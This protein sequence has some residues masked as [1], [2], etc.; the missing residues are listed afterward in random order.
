MASSPRA[1]RPRLL[2]EKYGGYLHNDVPREDVELTRDGRGQIGLLEGHCAHRGASLE[3]AR[4]EPQGIRCCYHGWHYEVDGTILEMPGEPPGSTF[5]DRF[6]HGAYPTL[7]FQGL[8]FTYMGPPE[9][10]PAFPIYDV[11][12]APG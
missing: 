11:Y 7:E 9:K 2:K 10:R 5:K 12:Q 4:V 3:Y 1:R 6:C 8:I